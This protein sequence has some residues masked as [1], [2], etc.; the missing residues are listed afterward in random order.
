[1]AAGSISFFFAHPPADLFQRLKSFYHPSMPEA[2]KCSAAAGHKDRRQILHDKNDV[3]EAAGQDHV[4]PPCST[5]MCS[6]PSNQTD[7]DE[8]ALT[9][10]EKES[11]SRIK[12]IFIR[13]FRH[14]K[15]GAVFFGHLPRRIRSPENADSESGKTRFCMCGEMPPCFSPYRHE[16][17]DGR[18]RDTDFQ[19]SV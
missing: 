8:C 12:I 6:S 14:F 4:F 7:T 5:G 9:P 18:V 16:Y 2:F 10:A 11:K 15:D 1:M 17:S 19:D 3:G 13:V